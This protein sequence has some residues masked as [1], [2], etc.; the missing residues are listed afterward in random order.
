MK[1]F[2]KAVSSPKFIFI[3]FL[4]LAAFATLQSIILTQPHPKPGEWPYTFYNN[5]VIFRQSFFHLIHHQDLYAAYYSE[6]WDLY[7]YSPAFSM[8]FGLLAYLPDAI[9]LFLWNALN[10][11]VLFVAVYKLPEIETKHKSFMLFVMGLELMTT[12]QNSQSNG[13]MAGLLILAFCM[14]EKQ[15]MGLAA[16][17]I[18]LT[19]FIKIF[20]IIA[21]I[22]FIF[23]SKKMRFVL[24]MI[25]WCL[26]FLLIPGFFSDFDQ[27][28]SIYTS[29][30]SMLA[31]DHS[32]SVGYSVLGWLQTWFR[33]EP[34][35][36][37]VLF[38]G[39]ILML[40][41]LLKLKKYTF[42]SFRLAM[43]ANILIWTV[44]F[45]HKAESPTFVIAVAGVALWFFIQVPSKV[46]IFLLLLTVLFTCLAPTDLFPKYI[47]QNIFETYVVKAVP[48]IIVWIKIIYDML[49]DKIKPNFAEE[50]TG[51]EKV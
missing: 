14:F 34:N 3:L 41:P 49:F 16:F 36:I 33:T 28:P 32:T 5:Y 26:L 12:M 47:R 10:A 11:F 31:N 21:C 9:G 20:G 44:I 29:W 50:T 13:L 39:A 38:I 7:K 4:L 15:R 30:L 40:L 46:N 25:G 23:Y 37:L 6:C 17:F 35:K 8:F 18:S 51:A 48:C 19:V 27:L 2:I 42:Y 1:V 45:N 24:Y 43:L 22:L